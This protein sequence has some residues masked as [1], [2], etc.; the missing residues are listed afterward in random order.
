MEIFAEYHYRRYDFSPSHVHC[1]ENAILENDEAWLDV[2][3]H[4]RKHVSILSSRRLAYPFEVIEVL[5][6]K[7]RLAA[8]DIEHVCRT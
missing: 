7:E 4:D 6:S 1:M 3:I 2:D 8:I 5:S